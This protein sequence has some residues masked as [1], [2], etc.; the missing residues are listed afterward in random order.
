MVYVITC[1][2]DINLSIK[3]KNIM[4]Y[5]G[6]INQNLELKIHQY[7]R[8]GNWVMERA[9]GTFSIDWKNRVI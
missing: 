5:Y 2:Q 1:E 8:H 4:V 3:Q 9:D 7:I 6:N